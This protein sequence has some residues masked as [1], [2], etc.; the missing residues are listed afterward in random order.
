[1]PLVRG[2]NYKVD[3]SHRDEPGVVEVHA[4]DT[5]I[6][7][8]LEGT[9]TPVTGGTLVDGKTIEPG[10]IRGRE[11]TGGETRVITKGDVVVIPNGTPH[12]FKEVQGPSNYYVVKVR[13]VN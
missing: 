8:M 7:Y 10:E 6:I 5:D 2:I 12:W 9:A 1:M 3:A 11:S 4:R 13:A